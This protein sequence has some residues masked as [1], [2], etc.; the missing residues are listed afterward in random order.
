[1][2]WAYPYKPFHNWNLMG[3]TVGMAMVIAIF[4]VKAS[5]PPFLPHLFYSTG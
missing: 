4:G 5:A 3:V 1:M 2:P